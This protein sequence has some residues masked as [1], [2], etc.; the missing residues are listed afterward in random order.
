MGSGATRSAA[1]LELFVLA[2]LQRPLTMPY[3]ARK[4]SRCPSRKRFAI[5]TV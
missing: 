1:N 3:D 5:P 2:T 4:R